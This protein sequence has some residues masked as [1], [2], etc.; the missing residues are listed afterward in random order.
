MFPLNDI[1][2]ASSSTSENLIE[3]VGHDRV[4]ANHVARFV[5]L[6]VPCSAAMVN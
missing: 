6:S 3:G 5:G 1:T 4:A 2:V